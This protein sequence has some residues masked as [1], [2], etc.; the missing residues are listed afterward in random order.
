MFRTDFH[1]DA[2]FTPLM[3]FPLE[4]K[5]ETD[6]RHA[7]V[8]ICIFGKESMQAKSNRSHNSAFTTTSGNIFRLSNF[9]I[10]NFYGHCI[11]AR[12]FS[13]I[14]FASLFYPHFFPIWS[15]KIPCV[16]C[17]DGLGVG[18]GGKGRNVLTR[19]SDPAAYIGPDLRGVG[20][21]R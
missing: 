14:H 16:P 15:H 6:I 12:T 8:N 20:P 7:D 13:A 19:V 4:A 21:S 17:L 5:V 11:G 18:W 1:K 2:Y 9:A 3:S 10:Y